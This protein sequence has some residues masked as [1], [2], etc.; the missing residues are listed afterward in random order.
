MR[1]K[2]SRDKVRFYIVVGVALVVI[3]IAMNL[4]SHLFR[5]ALGVA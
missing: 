3:T 4:A 1:L 2:G 5:M